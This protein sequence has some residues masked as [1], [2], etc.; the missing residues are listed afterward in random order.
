MTAIRASQLG[1]TFTIGWLVFK[2]LFSNVIIP[3]IH[4][5][6]LEYKRAKSISHLSFLILPSIDKEP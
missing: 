2:F 6:E 5:D 1:L 4:L 3:S